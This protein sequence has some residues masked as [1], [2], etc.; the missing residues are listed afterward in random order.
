MDFVAARKMMVD[1]Q[2]RVNDVT[3]RALQA[4][5]LAVPRERFC[6]PDRAFSAYA[7]AECEIA[8]GRVLMLPR[9]VAKLLSAVD[10]QPGETALA[11]GAPYAGA[12][13]ARLGARVTAQEA[14]Q[15]VLDV[16][17]PALADA[18]IETAIAPFDQPH[19]AGYDIIIS[20]G[21]VP[22]RP[23]AWLDA[24]AEGG[25]LAVV[26]RAGASGRGI[27]Y[28]RGREGFSRRDLFDAAPPMLAGMTPQPAFSF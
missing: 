10:A 11:I 22:L 24:L 26:E 21:A 27:L 5:L 2:V 6:A 13:L 15:A 3:D 9:E 23:Q 16:V 25:R 20:E 8:N 17:A 12:V 19:G 7:E 18:G 4:A 1:S 28:V 14:D